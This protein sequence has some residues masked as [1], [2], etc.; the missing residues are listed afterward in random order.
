M[1]RRTTLLDQVSHPTVLEQAFLEVRKAGGAPGVDGISLERYSLELERTLPR[2]SQELKAGHYAPRPVRRVFIPKSDG[3]SRALGIPC[4]QDRLVA[5]AL[6]RVL[7]P[8]LESL[9]C[10]GS[11]AYR[12]GRGARGAIAKV[13]GHLRAGSSHVV[14][15]DIKDFFPS[16]DRTLLGHFLNQELARDP[17]VT[18][19]QRMISA[20]P[21]GEYSEM[22][23]EQG[24]PLSPLL[25]NMYLHP[26]DRALTA[27]GCRWVR[28]SDNALIACSSQQE[29][30]E[31]LEQASADLERLGLSLNPEKSRVADGEE[32]FPFLG[33]H[34]SR[35]GIGPEQ[36]AIVRLRE[37]LELLAG[38]D[39]ARTPSQRVQARRVQLLG[40]LNYYATLAGVPVTDGYTLAAALEL[41]QKQGEVSAARALLKADVRVVD[42]E[43][44]EQVRRAVLAHP[45]LAPLLDDLDQA[46]AG[47]PDTRTARAVRRA[48]EPRPADPVDSSL[49]TPPETPPDPWC[50]AEQQLSAGDFR[51]ALEAEATLRKHATD[52]DA[53]D[54]GESS[55]PPAPDTHVASRADVPARLAVPSR[56]QD[57]EVTP[58]SLAVQPTTASR[59]QISL[60]MGLF[61]G[62]PLRH[63]RMWV[64]SLGRR[65]YAPVE[66]PLD[67]IAW[68][69]H[70]AGDT[71]LA[72]VLAEKGLFYAAVIDIDIQ[73]PAFERVRENAWELAALLSQTQSFAITVVEV[74]RELGIDTLLEDSGQKGRHVWLFFSTPTSAKDAHRLIRRLVERA[75]EVPPEL[76]VDTLPADSKKPGPGVPL[77]TLPLGIH[78]QS[79]R[80]SRLLDR[81]GRELPELELTLARVKRITPEILREILSEDLPLAKPA[82]P[83]TPP[84]SR[85]QP[86]RVQHILARCPVSAHLDQKARDV[87]HLGHRE[88]L[89]LLHVFGHLQEEGAEFLHD[90]MARCGNYDPSITDRYLERLKESPVSCP[91]IR[92]WLPEL[93]RRIPCQCHFDVPAGLW[94]SPLLHLLTFE[95]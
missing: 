24:S 19:I 56:T 28:Y 45:A 53:E 46:P 75:G 91:R 71:T 80:R 27:E 72:L 74:A 35:H 92:E 86:H 73:K 17:V 90:V 66:G 84:P 42:P 82:A 21:P 61:R 54:E 16:I 14:L 78:L 3:G 18:L 4:V 12:P 22:G 38:E 95:V 60:L 63:A 62:D 57:S 67:E 47:F 59:Q 68:R 7:T 70:L 94:P 65:G 36:A 6:Q 85:L 76:A 93:T 29:A 26:W 37:R 9:F 51:A 25:S 13:L 69:S 34:I 30:E 50:D 32:G 49:L 48:P 1:L 20:A 81:Q 23:L 10:A 58:A 43:A 79:G 83:G 87:A 64:D 31:V 55:D 11:F 77:V 89:M 5:R 88:R 41:S 52:T 33:F 8:R 2:L 44:L 15:L 40:W 39:A